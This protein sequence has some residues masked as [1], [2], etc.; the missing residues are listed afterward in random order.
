MTLSFEDHGSYYIVRPN[1]PKINYEN[2]N[3]FSKEIVNA[4]EE[5]HLKNLAIDFLHVEFISSIG[6]SA[7]SIIKGIAKVNDCRVVLFGVNEEVLEI[8]EQT[9]LVSL[10]KLVDTEKEAISYLKSAKTSIK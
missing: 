2:A 9:G 5:K 10:Y 4:I 8:L 3:E 1:A 6:I 7:L